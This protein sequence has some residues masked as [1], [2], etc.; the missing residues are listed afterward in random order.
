M[1]LVNLSNV[2]GVII[3]DSILNADSEE[4]LN[5]SIEE[6]ALKGSNRVILD[7]RPVDHMN[8]LGVSNLVKLAAIAKRKNIVLFA[9]GLS[10]RYRELFAMAS[11]DKEINIIDGGGETGS[12]S[13]G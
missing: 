7:F 1:E 13:P 6:A 9:Y 4:L 2:A 5:K 11:L 3:L 12:L 8:S 10:K